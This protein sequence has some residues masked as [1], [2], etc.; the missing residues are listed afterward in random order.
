[1]WRSTTTRYGALGLLVLGAILLAWRV[2]THSEGDPLSVDGPS[3]PSESPPSG[4]SELR[5]PDLE[6][7]TEPGRRESLQPVTDPSEGPVSSEAPEAKANFEFFLTM[8]VVDA[9]GAPV[10]DRNLHLGY[11]LK[12]S[13][14]HPPVTHTVPFLVQTDAQGRIERPIPFSSEDL[15]FIALWLYD[16]ESQAKAWIDPVAIAPGESIDLGRVAL[17]QVR[18]RFPVPLLAG[19]VLDS[20]RQPVS[21]VSGNL[22]RSAFSEDPDDGIDPP[23]WPGGFGTQFVFEAN[24][25]FAAYGPPGIEYADVTFS[26]DGFELEHFIGL[27]IPSLDLQVE[28][29]R[30]LRLRGTLLVPEGGPDVREYGVWISQGDRGTGITAAADGSFYAL[31]STRSLRLQITHPTLGTTVYTQEFATVPNEDAGLGMIDLRQRL[32]VIDVRFTNAF[33]EPVA[34]QE[35][36]VEAE[37][38]ASNGGQYHTDKAGRFLAVMPFEVPTLRIGIPGRAKQTVQLD[39]WGPTWVL[40]GAP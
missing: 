34:K 13:R 39:E 40:P 28:M 37:G 17:L 32:R 19:R 30:R 22:N 31:G 29:A 14:E 33:G 27:P 5:N 24:G 2:S 6:P 4:L 12:E 20:D 26:A 15:Q 3:Q 35:L 21:G 25:R 10:V 9:Q 36:H 1:M 8:E 7:R 23:P 16:P 18:E 38:A 11:G